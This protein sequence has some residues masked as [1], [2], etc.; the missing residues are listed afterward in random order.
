M[1]KIDTKKITRV[2]AI[3]AVVVAFLALIVFGI[4][5]PIAGMEIG[6]EANQWR[7]LEQADR[8]GLILFA[9]LFAWVTRKS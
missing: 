5:L 1:R 7:A 6:D 4:V 2:V 8:D 9:I 3:V